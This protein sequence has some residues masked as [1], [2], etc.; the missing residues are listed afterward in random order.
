M[1]GRLI[2]ITEFCSHYQL[3]SGFVNALSDYELIHITR[4]D[5]QQFI[6]EDE[7]YLI[8]KYTRLHQDLNINV[9]GIEAVSN[10]LDKIKSLQREIENLQTRLRLHD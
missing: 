5:E 1:S 6:A 8:E 9:E 4:V 7:L 10:L 2:T 3:D